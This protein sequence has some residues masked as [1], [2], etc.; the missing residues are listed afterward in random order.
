MGCVPKPWVKGEPPVAGRSTIGRI[1]GTFR[2]WIKYIVEVLDHT[3]I[4]IGKDL[5][6]GLGALVDPFVRDIQDKRQKS[7]EWWLSEETE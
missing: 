6:Q 7:L 2:D 5:G 4:G 3:P 1:G